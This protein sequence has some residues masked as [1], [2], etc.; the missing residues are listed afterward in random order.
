MVPYHDDK[1]WLAL[2]MAVT[3][4]QA[5]T[6]AQEKGKRGAVAKQPD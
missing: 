1:S 3:N 4:W 5:V 2:L 6:W